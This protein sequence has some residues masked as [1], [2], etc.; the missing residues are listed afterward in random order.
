MI[1]KRSAWNKNCVFSWRHRKMLRVLWRRA[2]INRQ[3][4]HN[5]D[6]IAS[7]FSG[8]I[9]F[10]F[11]CRFILNSQDV[12]KRPELQQT[13]NKLAADNQSL[14][15]LG[16]EEDGAGV[17]SPEGD[18][19]LHSSRKR[20]QSKNKGGAH[21]SWGLSCWGY[22]TAWNVL[23]PPAGKIWSDPNTEVSS[24]FLVFKVLFWSKSS[25]TTLD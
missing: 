16:K 15:T 24:K 14:E 1:C 11:N 6:L 25:W 23:R 7:T 5:H 19:R 22:G 9:V 21:Y 4:I 17:E 18:S 20:R 10:F 12:Q 13:E 2:R 8:D 3:V